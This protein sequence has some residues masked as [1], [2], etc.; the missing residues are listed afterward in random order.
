MPV[1]FVAT[2]NVILAQKVG[3]ELYKL[4]YETGALQVKFADGTDLATKFTALSDAVA[5]QSATIVV[6]DIAARDAIASPKIGDQCWVKDATG[7]S[8]VNSG[9]AKYLY[10]SAEAGWV[11]TAEVESL[12]VILDWA[13][14]RNKP[15][16]TVQQIDTAV[17]DTATNKA[18]VATLKTDVE[19]LETRVETLETGAAKKWIMHV[20]TLPDAVPEDLNEGGL[21]IV[22]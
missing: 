3:E 2:K 10:E 6:A 14:I 5:G 21:L 8:T 20:E 18:D 9:G 1:E 17:I 4:H 12:D 15:T 11:K 22:G 7:D 19:S 13:D 16:S